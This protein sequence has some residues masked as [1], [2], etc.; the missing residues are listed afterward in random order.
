[1]KTSDPLEPV[2][3]SIVRAVG[4]DLRRSNHR[5]QRVVILLCIVTGVLFSLVGWYLTA[6]ANTNRVGV[7]RIV[8]CTTPGLPCFEE[9]QL[10]NNAL[11]ADVLAHLNEEHLVLKCL[12]KVEPE[13]ILREGASPRCEAE[14]AEE[15]K[16]ILAELHRMQEEESRRLR[17]RTKPNGQPK[18]DRR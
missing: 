5:L 4:E 8:E 18:P 16:R 6:T 10:R 11:V 9:Q 2:D 3:N 7:R 17:E 13:P 1:M 15:T 14:A 12:L